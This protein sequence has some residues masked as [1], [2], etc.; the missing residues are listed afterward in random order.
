MSPYL[1]VRSVILG[2]TFESQGKFAPVWLLL[3]ALGDIDTES[4]AAVTY[5]GDPAREVLHRLRGYRNGFAYKELEAMLS[6]YVK[7]KS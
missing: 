1:Y 5:A 6:Q 4:P 3:S 7:V 2:L